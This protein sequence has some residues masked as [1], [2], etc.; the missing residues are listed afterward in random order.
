MSTAADAG[1]P[2]RYRIVALILAAQTMA[3]VG[4]LGIPALAALIRDDLDLTLTQAGSLLSLY[5]I[6]P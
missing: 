3:N 4:P 6:G 1:L 5:S 2:G